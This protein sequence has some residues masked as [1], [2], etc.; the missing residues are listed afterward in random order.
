MPS[1]VSRAAPQG[2]PPRYAAAL[3]LVAFLF[4]SCYPLITIGLGDAPPLS[5]AILRALV[6]G[7]ALALVAALLRRPLPRGWR[8]WLGLA[9]I[10]LSTTSLG[11]LGMFYAA[12]F[13]SPG[14]AT[15]ITNTQPLLA[16]MLGFVLL[17]E[18]LQPKQSLGL[19]LG[20]LG[21][22]FISL[23]QLGGVGRAGFEIGL[24]YI[25][26]AASGVALGNVLMKAFS[27]RVDPLV[28]MAA[29]LL[30]GAVPLAVAATWREQPAAIVWS[31][32]FVASLLGLALLGTAL[33]YWLWFTL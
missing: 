9:A 24:A 17:R 25:I 19:L 33:A 29:Q 23:P 12:E 1:E 13:V 4:A 31:P 18:R 14:V 10:G 8:I 28:A 2:T 32:L 22:V 20:F 15:V 21:I 3:V 27:A 6:A 16:A 11:F 30:F 7:S 5:F 26:L